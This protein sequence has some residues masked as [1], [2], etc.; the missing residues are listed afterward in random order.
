MF[1]EPVKPGTRTPAWGEH[2]KGSRKGGRDLKVNEGLVCF[3]HVRCVISFNPLVTQWGEDDCHCHTHKET[4]PC[5]SRAYTFSV[6]D[7]GGQFSPG[8]VFLAS[9][10]S[11][12][13]G[14]GGAGCFSTSMFLVLHYLPLRIQSSLFRNSGGAEKNNQAKMRLWHSVWVSVSPAVFGWRPQGSRQ[15]R[16]ATLL[17]PWVGLWANLKICFP[18]GHR[19]G[20]F[21]LKCH[22]RCPLNCLLENYKCCFAKLFQ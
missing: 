22:M 18:V 14:R 15:H 5:G 2:L 12:S 20:H 8:D 3:R 16:G 6:S 9:N 10:A 1:E 7:Q 19:L 4:A 13:L 17:R 11:S 21:T